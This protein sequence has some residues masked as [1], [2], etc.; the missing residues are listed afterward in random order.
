[1]LYKFALS[2]IFLLF[3]LLFYIYLKINIV[4][5]LFVPASRGFLQIILVAFVLLYFF[6]LPA[7]WSIIIIALMLIGGTFI[8]IE[9]GRGLGNVFLISFSSILIPFLILATLLY[10]SGILSI[11][12][13]VFVPL[14][15]MIIGNTTK[16]ISAVYKFMRREIHE[17]REIIEAILI[18]GGGRK[19]IMRLT[20]TDVFLIIMIPQ[21][22]GLKVLGL[23]HIPGAM[24]G[25]LIAGASPVEAALYQ[26]YI[27]FSLFAASAISI[28][29]AVF[30]LIP[31]LEN[32]LYN[33]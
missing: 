14:S 11:S 19:E 6:K 15:G 23:I 26:I 9:R 16:Y 2:F 12:P 30:L 13:N 10:I 31:K 24:S 7:L 17:K 29:M 5:E 3:P 33:L 1:M 32:E 25:L 18:D 28:F 8:T 20:F 22:D 21:I 4:K 27:V